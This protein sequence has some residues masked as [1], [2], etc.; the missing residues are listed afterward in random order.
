MAQ[1]AQSHE[2]NSTGINN[3]NNKNNTRFDTRCISSRYEDL[4]RSEMS[5]LPN[6]ET[7]QQLRSLRAPYLFHTHS[8]ETLGTMTSHYFGQKGEI[9]NL[10]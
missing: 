8:T 5:L 1:L 7:T 2:C 6:T 10:F 4:K 9:V 3:N